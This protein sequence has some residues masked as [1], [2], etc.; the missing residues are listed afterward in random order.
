LEK[1][2]ILE[3]LYWEL[4]RWEY[5][6]IIDGIRYGEA[7]LHKVDWSRYRT[8]P[9]SELEKQRIGTCWDFVNYQHA[10]LVAAGVP[11][12]TYLLWLKQFGQGDD[13]V[14]TH[15]FTIAI[16]DN[17][18]YWF[19]QAL[20]AKRGIHKIESITDV[21][22]ELLEFYS[23]GDDAPSSL[24]LFKYDPDTFDDNLSGEEFVARATASEPLVAFSSEQNG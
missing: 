7:D 14:I 19:E 5:G 23:T 21:V 2:D 3:K 17:C 6:A 13:E 16:L 20:Y 10:I 11:D 15:T 18:K 4:D 24:A 22:K 9:I 12:E 1:S 8:C